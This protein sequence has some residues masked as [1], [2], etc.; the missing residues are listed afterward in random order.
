VSRRQKGARVNQ[1]LGIVDHGRAMRTRLSVLEC[2]LL[3]I[4]PLGL[5]LALFHPAILDVHNVGWLLQGTDNGENALG[6]QAWLNDA[7]RGWSLRTTLLNAP[8]GV[9]LLFTDSNPLLALLV[10]PIAAVLGPG[11]QFVG[12]WYLLCLCLQSVF[13]R[14]LLKP[15]ARSTMELWLG[16]A[17]LMMLPTLFARYVH[18]NLFAH[19]ILLWALWIFVEPR[20]A[21]DWRWWIGILGVA[22]LVHSY[23]LFMVAAIWATAVCKA[24]L[25]RGD[26][27]RV[28]G[29]AVL[30]VIVVALILRWHAVGGDFGNTRSYGLYGLPLD[31][32]WNPGLQGFSTLVPAIPARASREMEGFQ[33]LGAGL[34]ALVALSPLIVARTSGDAAYRVLVRQLAWLAPAYVVLV[35]LAV[36]HQID[37][38]GS[39]IVTLPLSTGA[40]ALLDPIRAS[41]RL[42]WPVAYTIVLLAIVSAYRLSMQRATLLLG[43]VLAVQLCDLAGMIRTVRAQTAQPPGRPTYAVTRDP[44]WPAAIAGARDVVIM[45]TDVRTALD[46]YQEI[47]WRAVLAGRPVRDVYAARYGVAT[48]QRYRAEETAFRAGQLDPRRLYVLLPGEPVPPGAAHRLRTLNGVRLLVAVR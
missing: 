3:A 23:L 12:L 19:W 37:F 27:L 33:Y 13:A 45:P 24:L 6:L 11:V 18:A 28:I 35:A 10:R 41:G 46:L 39:T 42:F 36:T 32:L 1:S 15:F 25:K 48:L 21:R 20:R 38:A 30:A 4:V 40:I 44:R 31:A 34:L 47:A 14:A 26:R 29:C 2:A 8:E 9:T 22:A 17:L 5:F 7:A 43:V 16:V